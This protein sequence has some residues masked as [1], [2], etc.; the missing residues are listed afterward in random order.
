MYKVL[1]ILVIECADSSGVCGRLCPVLVGAGEHQEAFVGG[2]AHRVARMSA[3]SA[4]RRRAR[5]ARARLVLVGQ[6]A[7]RPGRFQQPELLVVRLPRGAHRQLWSG[8]REVPPAR[9]ARRAPFDPLRF[10][11]VLKFDIGR[12]IPFEFFYAISRFSITD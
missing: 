7:A 10:G 12:W 3:Q 1:Y 11:R 4:A 6:S 8:H 9:L 5:P 2:R